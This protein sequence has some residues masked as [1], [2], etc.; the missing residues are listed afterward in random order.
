VVEVTEGLAD[1]DEIVTAGQ[2]KIRDG[3]PVQP[4]PA[5]APSS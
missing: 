5:P 4:M 3:V 1:G 2:I